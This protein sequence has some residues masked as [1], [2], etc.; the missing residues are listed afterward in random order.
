[1]G[2]PEVSFSLIL[3]PDAYPA[4]T[5]L[6]NRGRHT[7]QV[8]TEEMP[9]RSIVKY[10]LGRAK[11]GLSVSLL[12]AN[13]KSNYSGKK[14]GCLY[15]QLYHSKNV[16]VGVVSSPYLHAKLIIVDDETAYLGSGNLTFTSLT[17]NREVG[18]LLGRGSLGPLEET[19]EQDYRKAKTPKFSCP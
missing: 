4:I 13:Q 14:N 6:F 11:K 3:S 2:I 5:A 10:L 8:E 7:I 19:F 15:Q 18:L 1:M 9:S 17:R 16:A 12:L